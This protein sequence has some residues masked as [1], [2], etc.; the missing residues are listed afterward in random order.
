VE[1]AELRDA[2]SDRTELRAKIQRAAEHLFERSQRV[3]AV[4]MALRGLWLSQ[5]GSHDHPPGP[6]QFLVEANR[7][8]LDGLTELFDA[9]RDELTV[10]PRTAALLLRTL[11]LG[12]RHPGAAHAVELTPRV[13][14]DVLLDG[15]R[16]HERED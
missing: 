11:V 1:L 5:R 7:A 4:L 15:I 9:H 12:S 10:E 8:L 2:L 3:T 16:R 14:T 13:V 6:P